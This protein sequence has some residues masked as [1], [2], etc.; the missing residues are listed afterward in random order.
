MKKYILNFILILLATFSLAGCATLSYVG[1]DDTIQKQTVKTDEDFVFT[2]YKK[3][4]DNINVKVGISKSPIIEIM[5]LY[6]QIENLSYDTPYVF[7]VEDLELRD[8]EGRLQ[9]ITSDNYLNL[10]HSQEAAQMSSMSV[11]A[12]TIQNMTG[13]MTNY[14]EINQSAVQASNQEASK[15]TFAKMETIGNQILKHSTKVSATIQPRKSRYFYF[16]FQNE[17]N[18]PLTV[19]YKKLKYL[20]K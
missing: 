1:D 5:A 17:D 12:P 15:S 3:N 6:I 20:F 16:F 13:M 2:V 10:Y 18:Y 14:N 19:I 8:S 7:R 11:L 4:M 9:F